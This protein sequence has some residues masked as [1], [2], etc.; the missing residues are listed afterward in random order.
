ME[1][2]VEYIKD[3]FQNFLRIIQSITFFDV[4]DIVILTFLVYYL[5]K[6]IR[7]TR[8]M[9]LLKGILFL[10]IISVL[11]QIFN[12]KAMGFIFDNFLQVGIIAV[13]IVFQP[14]LRRILEKVGTKVNPFSQAV[15]L[16]PINTSEPRGKAIEGI[17]EACLVL[18]ESKTGALIVIERETKLGDIIEKE[19]TSI[20]NA[21]CNTE[22]FCNIFIN[23]APLHDGAVIIRNNRI[24]AAGCFLPNTQNDS[25]LSADLGSRHRAA[26]GMSENSDALV[27]VVSEET[28]T[29]STAKDGQLARVMTKS[30]LM[31]ILNQY[32]PNKKKDKR[33]KRSDVRENSEKGS[34]ENAVAGITAACASLSYSRTDALIIIE[35]ENKFDDDKIIDYDSACFIDSE[36]EQKIICNLF[37]KKSPMREGAILIRG[38]RI[39]AAKCMLSNTPN[40]YAADY[41]QR[42]KEA[43]S[44]SEN[45]D[46]LVIAVSKGTGMISAAK[47][48]QIT[49]NITIDALTNILQTHMPGAGKKKKAR[50]N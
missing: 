10:V 20:I 24:Y 19:T 28:G 49:R 11:V 13:I 36:C 16:Q 44:I 30:S 33:D 2:F 22:L 23:K 50:L 43:L 34:P 31:K 48:G 45:S 12:L 3:I 46:A 5:I 14:E 35:L 8:A 26:V 6:L 17:A 42:Q 4:L 25:Y 37:F 1:E 15:D 7:E 27:I 21:E 40:D 32:M 18:H 38:G 39:C 41:D 29:I 9:Q 47:D